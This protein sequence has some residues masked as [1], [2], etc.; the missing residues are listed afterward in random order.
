[1]KMIVLF[2]S[3]FYG[4]QVFADDLYMTCVDPETEGR[5]LKIE[6]SVLQIGYGE[7]NK[8]FSGRIEESGRPTFT[9]SKV[10][11]RSLLKN[12]SRLEFRT[13]RDVITFDGEKRPRWVLN[14]YDGIATVN[15]YSPQFR[16]QESTILILDCSLPY[17][18]LYKELADY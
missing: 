5:R 9:K 2:L 17:Y 3:L 8:I 18:Q 12:P 16:A 15:F 11:V 14:I 10:G 7:E 4:A 13:E 6:L 1:M